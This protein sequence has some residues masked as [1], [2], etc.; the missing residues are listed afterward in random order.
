MLKRF[1]NKVRSTACAVKATIACRKAEGYVDSGVK[2]LIAVV[3]GALLLTL[4]YSLV[5][6]TIMPSVS[7]KITQLFSY[8]GT[9]V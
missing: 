3:V 5:G 1:C 9:N 7:G 6:D 4:L 2:I 8:A